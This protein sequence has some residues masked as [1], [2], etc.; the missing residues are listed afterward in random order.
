MVQ[1]FWSVD[2]QHI[3]VADHF[4]FDFYHPYIPG[5]A[6]NIGQIIIAI[7]MIII[8]I[9]IMILPWSPEWCHAQHIL[10]ANHFDVDFYHPYIPR[11]A[12]PK[13]KSRLPLLWSFKDN[14]ILFITND[15]FSPKKAWC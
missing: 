5:R 3:L 8:S 15:E 2:A 14:I 12:L 6:F 1:N 9:V 4:D 10:V 13:L 11:R 7:A